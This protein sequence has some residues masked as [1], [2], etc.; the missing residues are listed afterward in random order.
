V[1]AFRVNTNGSL[2]PVADVTDDATLN[3]GGVFDTATIRIGASSYLFAAGAV[4]DGLSVFSI[5]DSGALTS[6]GNV[7]DAGTRRASTGCAALATVV[8][9]GNTVPS[10]LAAA[11]D[12]GVSVVPHATSRRIARSTTQ[13]TWT[14]AASALTTV[15]RRRSDL[16]HSRS[17]R[18]AVHVCA[19]RAH[20]VGPSDCRASAVVIAANSYGAVLAKP[21]PTCP[22]PLRCCSPARTCS[23]QRL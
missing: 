15:I 6:I 16:G 22:T 20:L 21:S 13:P 17:D 3:L 1:S 8:D 11:I 12:N 7:S 19:L 23:V 5:A 18:G 9:G 14:R 2:T 10:L 4:D